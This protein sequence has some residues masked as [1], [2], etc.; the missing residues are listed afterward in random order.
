MS[1]VQ[2]DHERRLQR[3]AEF[4]RIHA[5]ADP[6]AAAQQVL[7]EAAAMYRHQDLSLKE[8]ETIRCGRMGDCTWATVMQQS[9]QQQGPGEA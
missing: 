4:N 6:L 8:G 9:L 3:E 7:P 2:T 5:A 1:G